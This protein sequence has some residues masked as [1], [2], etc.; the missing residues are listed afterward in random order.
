[1][2]IDISKNYSGNYLMLLSKYQKG[3][4]TADQLNRYSL[5]LLLWKEHCET[6]G[7]N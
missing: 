5:T 4:I 2:I 7:G 1:M 3:K 6:R